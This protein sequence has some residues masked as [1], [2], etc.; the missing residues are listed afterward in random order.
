M[1]HNNIIVSMIP[2]FN[3]DGLLPEGIHW[4]SWQEIEQRFGQTA[5]RRA[6]LTGLK[7]ALGALRVAGCRAVFLDGSFVTAKEVPNDYDCC[8]DAVGVDP[9]RLDPAFLNFKNKREAQKIRYGG[10]FF[11]AQL[12]EG[13][14]GRVFLD[15]FQT[16]K[17]TGGRKGIVAIDLRSWR[18]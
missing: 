15:F 3:P 1:Q 8:W 4:A 6:L 7:A 12:P 18:P 11:P 10:E 5:H 2:P 9:A 16:D 14:T 13:L 17:D